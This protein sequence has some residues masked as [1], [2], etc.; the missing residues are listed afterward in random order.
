MAIKTLVLDTMFKS[1]DD[2]VIC[3]NEAIAKIGLTVNGEITSPDDVHIVGYDFLSVAGEV[4]ND[5][6]V[7]AFDR[8]L[9]ITK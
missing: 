2:E 9:E 5:N 7:A 3:E 6:D 4:T 1:L 8:M